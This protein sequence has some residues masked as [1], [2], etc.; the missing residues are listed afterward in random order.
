[1][2][3]GAPDNNMNLDYAAA[4][5]QLFQFCNEMLRSEYDSN[6]TKNGAWYALVIYFNMISPITTMLFRTSAY[7][8]ANC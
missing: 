7:M 4:N 6:S 1:M 8:M 5:D 3:Y 2:Q